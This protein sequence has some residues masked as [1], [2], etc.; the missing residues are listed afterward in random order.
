MLSFATML[1]SFALSATAEKT[2]EAE[3]LQRLSVAWGRA[4]M[5]MISE[6]EEPS[7][8]NYA[9]ALEIARIAAEL[10]PNDPEGWRGV[11]EISNATNG[12]M[13]SANVAANEAVI[14]LCKLSP[15]NLV[16]RLS[17]LNEVVDRSMTADE[18]IAAYEHFLQ[19]SSVSKISTQVASRLAFDYSLL[20]RRRGDGDAS[21]MQL[22]Q[23]VKLD[24]SF[25]AATSQLAAYELETS[26][27]ITI[28][29][30]AL[31]EAILANPNEISYYK[32][33]ADMCLTQGMYEPA[34]MLLSIA[35]RIAEKNVMGTELE[36]LLIQQMLARW[37]MGKHQK[38]DDLFQTRKQQVFDIA[39]EKINS[40]LPVETLT[41]M[42]ATMNSIHALI[43]KSGSLPNVEEALADAD[44][45]L[46]K[47]LE[48]AKE[49]PTQRANF[50]LAKTWLAVVLG[51]NTQSVESWLKEIEDMGLL[52]PEAKLKFKGWMKLREGLTT[53][54]IE[55]LRPIAP[56]NPG[57][58]LGY[59]LALA[60]SGN[61]KEAAQEFAAI[62]RADR[63]NGI[64]LYAN[65]QL[66]QIVNKRV[67]PSDK[68][69]EIQAA[70][71]RLPKDFSRLAKDETPFVKVSAEFLATTAKPFESLPCKIEITNQSPFNLAITSDGPIESRAALVLELISGGKIPQILPPIVILIDQ[72]IEIA[73]NEKMSFVVDIARTSAAIALLKSPLE[74]AYLQL[75][76]ITNFRLTLESVVP[77][78][79]GRATSK[80]SIRISPIVCNAAWRDEALG[81]IHHCD[82]PDDL[83]T[84]V[85]LAFDLASRSTD[86]ASQAEV[87]EGWA[88][89]TEA[90]KSL[91][92]AAQAW[93]LM[94]L[95][96]EP[97]AMT[98]PIM[99]AAKES[100][101]MRV[102]LSALLR[103][104]DAE[105]DPF[106]NVIA[107]GGNQQLIS[108]ASGVRARITNRLLRDAKVIQSTEEFG[109]FGGAA[110]VK[111]IPGQAKP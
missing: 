20:L 91:P 41:D 16:M 7:P 52:S 49:N 83:A 73:R 42:T 72:Q 86:T 13:S 30:N 106:L 29:A 2:V 35:A 71:A 63:S 58:R 80:N 54:A 12:S 23:A 21:L 107:R 85:L 9:G 104:V 60:K 88:E 34:D 59:A 44:I 53:E 25:P 94:V 8:E 1:L 46:D 89:V 97:I 82:K 74:G 103:W 17:R 101:D 68:A 70:L 32:E 43:C 3:A 15:N 105:D 48:N 51:A 45:V 87:K 18:R 11:L 65:D 27:S 76:M 75:E 67:G 98:D 55:I 77:G 26:S 5:Q 33:L 40:G 62:I 95:P 102:Q 96:K 84:L 109:I 28:N 31:V 6:P 79:L 50:L 99:K 100:Q 78:F 4:S 66:F 93:T 90:W 37:G 24:P 69:P 57:A 61:T 19:P 110:K 22:R 56:N 81:S 36:G 47:Q 111:D 108:I 39:K 64:S 14:R 38:A 10:A 92:P